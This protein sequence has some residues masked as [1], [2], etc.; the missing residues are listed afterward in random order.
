M[1][2]PPNAMRKMVREKTRDLTTDLPVNLLE[3][4]G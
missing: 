2:L 4:E 1:K 3:K